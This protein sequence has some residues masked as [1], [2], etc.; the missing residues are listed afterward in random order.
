MNLLRNKDGRVFLA[1]IDDIEARQKI[2]VT[3]RADLDDYEHRARQIEH[4]RRVV[5]VCVVVVLAALLYVV[6]QRIVLGVA[7]G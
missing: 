5:Q 3:K 7:H 4:S 1:P 2:T 6:V